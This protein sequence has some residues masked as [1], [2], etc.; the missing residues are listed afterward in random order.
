MKTKE[1]ISA[2]TIIKQMSYARPSIG[3]REFVA[4][5]GNDERRGGV[6]CKVGRGNWYVEIIW[7]FLDLYDVRFR[8]RKSDRVGFEVTDV[9]FDDLPEVLIRGGDECNI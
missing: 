9:F 5:D 7:N 3:A 1:Q 4:L 8:T 6:K 2:E